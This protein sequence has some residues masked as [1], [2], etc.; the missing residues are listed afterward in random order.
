MKPA[1]FELIFNTMKSWGFL[2]IFSAWVFSIYI[3]VEISATPDEEF[4]KVMISNFLNSIATCLFLFGLICQTKKAI[5]WVTCSVLATIGFNILIIGGDRI[6]EFT[7]LQ[8]IGLAVVNG[9]CFLGFP[10]LIKKGLAVSQEI[11]D[12][13]E[14]DDAS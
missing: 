1:F 13:K 10:I 3:N 11:T 4:A 14:V 2:I 8:L 6:D 9:L 5:F 7:L 12:R